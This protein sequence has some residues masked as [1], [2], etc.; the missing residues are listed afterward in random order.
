MLV[1]ACS[2][3]ST[4]LF[5]RHQVGDTPA[6]HRYGD[7]L[8]DGKAPYRDFYLEYP[9]GSLPMFV[10]PTVASDYPA[11]FKGI[12][13]VL[14]ALAIVLVAAVAERQLAACLLAGLAPLALGPPYLVNFDVWPAFLVV[15]A[16]V[17]LVRNR[18]RLGFVLLALAIAAKLYALVLVPLVLLYVERR[19]LRGA[20]LAGIATLAAVGLPFAALAPGGLGYSLSIPV[21][22]PLQIES[23]G[24]SFL[25]A[26]HRLGLYG[27]HVDS[28]FNSQNLAGG[29]ARALAVATTLVEI[30]AIV[31]VWSLF[32]RGERSRARLLAAS[33]AA[34]TAFVAFGKVLSPQ[35][36]VWLVPLVAL[37]PELVPA[38]LLAAALVL[39]HAWFPSRY[40]ELVALSWPGWL[41]LARD[42]TLVALFVLLLRAIRP[43]SPRG[44]RPRGA[45]RTGSA[46]AP[47]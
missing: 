2:V 30:A 45:R 39:T 14:A 23:L 40:G 33:A 44:R 9:P 41:V 15:A 31:L 25:L 4:G 13:L 7:A 37:L 16:L 46:G 11:A 32:A 18:P 24:A 28:R 21:R 36:L 12:A 42:L 20:V 26:A 5:D 27:G 35:Y 10:A 8:R 38:A 19:R 47:T 3:P 29:T 22:R 34:V 1:A 6:Y 17:A 43:P